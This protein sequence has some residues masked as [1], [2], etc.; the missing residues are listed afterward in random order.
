MRFDIT[1]FV[2]FHHGGKLLSLL[3][4]VFVCGVLVVV[5]VGV[6]IECLRLRLRFLG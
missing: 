5:V 2:A 1:A 6:F 3:A 4:P